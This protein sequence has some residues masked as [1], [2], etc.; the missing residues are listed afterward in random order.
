MSMRLLQHSSIARAR[1]RSIL[2]PS[3]ASGDRHRYFTALVS[4]A[5]LYPSAGAPIVGVLFVPVLSFAQFPVGGR[6]G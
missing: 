5:R 6:F 4:W 2:K 1:S 3:S